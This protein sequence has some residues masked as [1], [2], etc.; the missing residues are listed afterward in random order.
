MRRAEEQRSGAAT[1]EYAMVFAGVILPI[2]SMLIFTGQL[3][4]VWNSAVDYT[5]EGARYAATHCYQGGGA[6]V[7]S[8]MR[9]NT[10]IM[11]DR[12]RFRDGQAEIE[13]TYFGRNAESGELEEFSCDGAECSRECVPDSVRVRIVNYQFTAFLSYLGLPPVTMPDFQT[14]LPI[15]S[16]GCSADSEECLP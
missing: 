10:P 6:N 13:V 16:A 9:E 15:E 11:F 4:W 3:L 14:T 7:V 8:Y 5:R 1:V 12:Q 2:T